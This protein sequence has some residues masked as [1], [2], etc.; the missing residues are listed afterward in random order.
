MIR[1][2][3]RLVFWLIKL[4]FRIVFGLLG[5]SFRLGIGAGKLT[6]K[7]AKGVGFSR[8]LAFGAGVGVGY[9]LGNPDARDRA[10]AFV[11]D[12]TGGGQPVEG[13]SVQPPAETAVGDRDLP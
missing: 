1:G 3:G 13:W 12:L 8:L 11:Q 5:G 2:L 4:P 9:L 10:V 7:T 6:G